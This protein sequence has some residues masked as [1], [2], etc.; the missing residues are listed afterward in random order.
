MEIEL[1]RAERF[2]AGV[3][4]GGCFGTVL[5]AE[6]FLLPGFGIVGVKRAALFAAIEAE[7]VFHGSNFLFEP[8]KRGRRTGVSMTPNAR[9]IAFQQV[10][11]G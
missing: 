1:R 5:R 7:A 4:L 2:V 9:P 3:E 8:A 11:P 10:V 6:T